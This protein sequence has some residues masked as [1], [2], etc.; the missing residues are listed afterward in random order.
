M[1]SL[2]QQQPQYPKVIAVLDNGTID[3]DILNKTLGEV[4][5]QIG[6]CLAGQSYYDL[7]GSPMFMLDSGEFYTAYVE[8]KLEKVKPAA[9]AYVLIDNAE[10]Y[11]V[12]IGKVNA[13]L[14]G[15]AIYARNILEKLEA[16]DITLDNNNTFHF[17][18]SKKNLT[19][20]LEETEPNF[21]ALL[22][23][24]ETYSNDEMGLD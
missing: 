18:L 3:L 10:S 2:I 1:S 20:E 4:E 15:A 6:T 13:D 16:T 5:D 19:L 12:Q 21:F 8:Y 14:N 22:V 7:I 17:V 9:A 23:N 24:I 11:P